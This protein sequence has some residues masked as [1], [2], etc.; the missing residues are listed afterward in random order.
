MKPEHNTT[1]ADHVN[2][3]T[4]QR[5][6]GGLCLVAIMRTRH[7]AFLPSLQRAMISQYV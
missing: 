1:A 7:A 4:R 3:A 2:T 5:C 6:P